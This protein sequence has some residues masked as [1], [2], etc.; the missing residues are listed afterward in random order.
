MQSAGTFLGAGWDF[1]DETVNG[2]KDIWRILEGQDYPH[3][4][5]ESAEEGE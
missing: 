3:L 5:W 4:W 2:T 1:V